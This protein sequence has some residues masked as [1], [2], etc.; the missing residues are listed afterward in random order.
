MLGQSPHIIQVTVSVG[1]RSKNDS[2]NYYYF[3]ESVSWYSLL[4]SYAS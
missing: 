2:K 3:V 1:I 4:R